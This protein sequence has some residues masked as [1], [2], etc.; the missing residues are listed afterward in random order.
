[1]KSGESLRDYI[2]HFSQKCHELLG[3]ADADIISTFWDST[4]SHTLVHE[5]SHEQLKTTKELLDI[6]TQH[7]SGKEAIGAAFILGNAGAAANDGW[8][9]PTKS[10]RKG[11]K[12]GKKGQKCQPHRVAIVA[13]NDDGDE[14]ADDSSE[15]LVAAVE[16]NFK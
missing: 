7:A 1:L 6:A 13:G 5:L 9:T 4:T 11:D 16:L 10:A 3:V 8:A 2:Q 12:G 14:E 15:E